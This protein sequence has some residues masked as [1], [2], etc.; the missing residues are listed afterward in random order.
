[1]AIALDAKVYNLA[2]TTSISFSHTTGSGANRLLVATFM[3]R[4]DVTAIS[5][6][7]TYGGQNLTLAKRQTDATNALSVEVWYLVAPPSGANTLAATLSAADDTGT[8]VS[9]YTGVAP[10]S[11]L[12]QTAGAAAATSVS[13]TPTVNNELIVAGAPN[14]DGTT[15]TAGAGE[16]LLFGTDEG[17]WATGGEYAIQTTATAQT[18]NFATW[19][20]AQGCIAVASFKA[21]T[22]PIGSKY[23]KYQAVKRSN[24]Y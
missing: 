18:I 13:I 12:D 4:N 7:P 5:G 15:P 24:F 22:D 20:S 17:T 3:I 10:S 1:M 16:T 9:T 8:I 21:A 2:T 11:P 14:E 19:T 23:R 6:T